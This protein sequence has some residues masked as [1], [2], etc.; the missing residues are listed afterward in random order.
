MVESKEINGQ[1]Y[2]DIDI[3]PLA[4]G[5]LTNGVTV[6]EMAAAYSAFP[7]NGVY[8]ESRTYTKVLDSNGEVLLDNQPETHTV[9]KESTAWYMNT[10][11]QSVMTSGGGSGETVTPTEPPTEAPL[12]PEGPDDSEPYIPAA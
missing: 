5:G 4:L 9:L 6:R 7:R 2:S 8:I 12:L 10:M 11:L 1:T 3:A